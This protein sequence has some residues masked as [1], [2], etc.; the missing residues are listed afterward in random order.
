MNSSHLT[1]AFLLLLSLATIAL[2]ERII[3]LSPEHQGEQDDNSFCESWKLAVE[4][5]NAGVWDV[6]PK[7]CVNFVKEYMTGEHYRS[8]SEVISEYALEYAKTVSI[9][10]DG[11]DAWVF[12]ID[13]TLLTNLPYYAKHGFG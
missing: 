8:D 3:R 4:T 10:G 2:S 7:R 5:N 9:A 12:N 1:I 6:V 11:K 13:E